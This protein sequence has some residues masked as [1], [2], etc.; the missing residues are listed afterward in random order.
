MKAALRTITPQTADT[1]TLRLDATLAFKPGQAVKITFPGDA[2][3]RFFSISSSPTEAGYIEVTV[4]TPEASPL[5]GIL[6]A[7]K[8]GDMLDVEGP[9]GKFSLPDPIKMPLCF[10]AAGSGVAPFRAMI[11][12]LLDTDPSVESWLLHSVKTRDDLIFRNDFSNWSGT[13]KQFHYVPTLTNDNDDNWDNETGRINETLVRKHL[14]S[15]PCCYLLCGP[16]TFV[17]DMEKMLKDQLNVN[18][19]HIRREQW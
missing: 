9:M 11:R 17:A 3:G 12:Y 19:D 16:P 1:H 10:V 8:R 15:K 18:P 2:K 6:K 5:A 4:K 13:Q 7:L 14:A